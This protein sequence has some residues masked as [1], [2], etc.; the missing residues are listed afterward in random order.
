M[1]HKYN[2]KKTQKYFDSLAGDYFSAY[3]PRDEILLKLILPKYKEKN[4]GKITALDFGCGGGAL[5]LKMLERGIKAKGIEKH[6]E[7]YQLAQKRLGESGFDKANVIKGSIKELNSLPKNSFDF[8]ILMGVL[9]YLPPHQRSQLYVKIHRL[10]KPKGHIIST[11]QNAFFDLFTF[12]KYTVDLFQ[13]KFFKPLGLD[14]LLGQGITKD[15]KSLM[16]HPDKPDYSASTA[17]DNIYV[18]TTNP[19]TIGEELA[20]YKFKL[21]Q[22]YFYNFFPL[23]RLIENKYKGQLDKFKKQFEVTRSKEWY[24]HFMANAFVVD[25]VKEN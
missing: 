14:K 4:S 21:L 1:V 23:P 24:G 6:D 17:R 7:L 16:T 25:C 8:I 13:E 5:L 11:F 12:N 20:S 3:A 2:A 19:L 18:E 22:K 9:Q 10:L 15:L